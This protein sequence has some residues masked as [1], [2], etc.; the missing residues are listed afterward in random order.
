MIQTSG[1]VRNMRLIQGAY[2]GV[3]PM[4]ADVMKRAQINGVH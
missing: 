3:V 4:V 1:N 2:P